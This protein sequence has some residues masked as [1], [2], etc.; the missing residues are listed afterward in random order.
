M[1]EVEFTSWDGIVTTVAV[2]DGESVMRLA[3]GN[4]VPGIVGECGGVLSCATCH[5]FV[6]TADLARL[7]EMGPMEDELLEGAAEERR[8]GSR[9]SCQLA[10][11]HDFGTLHVT[12]P[13][14]QD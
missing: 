4:G 14:Y 6:D 1:A 12:T 2:K 9:L 5:V 11:P 3:V 7:T 13:E 8:A 10:I